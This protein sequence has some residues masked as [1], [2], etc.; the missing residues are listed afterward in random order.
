MAGADPGACLSPAAIAAACASLSV[1]GKARTL[2]SASLGVGPVWRTCLLPQIEAE[3][4]DVAVVIVA[5]L[6]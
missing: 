2:G 4:G 1:Q 5:W 3:V 6:G